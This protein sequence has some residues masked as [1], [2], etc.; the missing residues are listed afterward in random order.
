MS[1]AKR[2]TIDQL[3]PR[4]ML[5]PAGLEALVVP[6]TRGKGR[7]LRLDIGG[8]R[9]DATRAW[10]AEHPDDLVIALE[11]HRPGIAGLVQDLEASGPPNVRVA[12]AD[13]TAL[14]DAWPAGS[15]SAIRVLFPDPWPKRRHVGRRLVD[16]AFV[17]RATDLLVVGGGLH[18]ATDWSDY[19]DQMRSALA[20]EGR[21]EF[22]VDGHDDPP[23]PDACD[24]AAST[25]PWWSA[26]PE[27]PITTY[28]QRGLDGNRSIV[29]LVA[30]RVR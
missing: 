17:R 16:P 2:A 30:Q 1:A 3:G 19:A 24:G 4:W 27:R 18:L 14:V 8:G 26:R 7:A 13:A 29:D 11:L 6:A 22:Q 23:A 12:E 20:T 9:G 15:F 21:L 28:E 5:D 10:A 25:D